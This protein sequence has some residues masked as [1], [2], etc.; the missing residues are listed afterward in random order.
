[1]HSGKLKRFSPTSTMDPCKKS[2]KPMLMNLPFSKCK[3]CYNQYCLISTQTFLLCNLIANNLNIS[4]S[5]TNRKMRANHEPLERFM[6][7]LNN[8]QTHKQELILN[9]FESILANKITNIIQLN[10]VSMVSTWIYQNL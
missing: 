2:H 7:C 5:W 10:Y 8:S 1:M 3:K 6:N 4:K 9:Y